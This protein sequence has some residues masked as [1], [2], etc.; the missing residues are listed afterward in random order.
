MFYLLP[1]VINVLVAA[2]P[3]LFCTCREY[4]RWST[5]EEAKS[6]DSIALG[7]LTYILVRLYSGGILCFVAQAIWLLMMLYPLDNLIASNG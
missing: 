5:S 2:V 3:F 4:R 1:P 6:I 7:A